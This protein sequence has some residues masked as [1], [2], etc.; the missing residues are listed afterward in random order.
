MIVYISIFLAEVFLLL[1]TIAV[2]LFCV[3]TAYAM[4]KAAPFV[5][6]S[7]EHV[8]DML[9]IARLQSSDTLMDLGSGDGRILRKA[10]GL[11]KQAIGIEINPV[12]YWWSRF[13]LRKKKNT[14]VRR[15]DLWHTD[16]SQV[17]V[18]TLFFIA[19]KMNLLEEKIRR[20]MKTGSRVVSYGF[21]FPNWQYVE[22]NDKVYLY[23]V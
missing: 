12:L 1:M 15:E 11:V 10:S 2:T 4:L 19:H 3:Y 21:R 17:S 5:P 18:L 23:I 6:T 9:R 8:D 7:K 13:I 16:L 22:K 20:E 14:M